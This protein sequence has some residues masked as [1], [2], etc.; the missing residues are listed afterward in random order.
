MGN[1]SS[2]HPRFKQR[3]SNSSS[4]LEHCQLRGLESFK[5]I[6]HPNNSDLAEGACGTLP[7]EMASAGTSNCHREASLQLEKLEG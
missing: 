3:F 5:I 7:M 2:L 6:R 1:Q 4:T